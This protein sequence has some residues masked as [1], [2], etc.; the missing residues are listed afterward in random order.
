MNNKNS[1]RRSGKKPFSILNFLI[2]FLSIVLAFSI[3]ISI[4][5]LRD[6]ESVSYDQEQYLYYRLS[7]GEYAS[8][9]ERWYENGLGNENNP[10]VKNVLDYYAV[11][12]YFEKAFLANAWEKAGNTAKAQKLR[13]QM[14]EFEPQMGQFA[15][16]KQKIEM[17]F[18]Q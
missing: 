18:E 4:H 17:I 11:G 1:S 7:D 13:A 8:L 10:Q 12:R 16:E 3:I 15:A 14:E 9:A 2:V 6:V 5:I